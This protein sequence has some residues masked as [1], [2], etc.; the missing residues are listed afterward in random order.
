MGRCGLSD[1]EPA[2][3]GSNPGRNWGSCFS[4]ENLYYIQLL[5]KPCYHGVRDVH[6]GHLEESVLVYVAANFN[7]DTLVV[8]VSD[9]V[10]ISR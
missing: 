3:A 8:L 4:G 6:T 9:G 10:I 1:L 5:L 7:L 2:D